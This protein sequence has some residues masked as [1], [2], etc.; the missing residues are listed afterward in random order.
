[1]SPILRILLPLVISTVAAHAQPGSGS[2][3]GEPEGASHGYDLLHVAIDV[4]FDLPKKLVIGSVEHSIH[5][6]G[7]TSGALEL[8]A[9]E[10]MGFRSVMVDGAPAR[11]RHTGETLAIY[12]P[13]SRKNDTMSVRIE[14]TVSPAKGL[15]FIQ[16]D[17]LMPL[18]RNQIWTQGEEEDNHFW[19]PIYDHPD[20]RT[21]TEIRATVPAGW[22]ALSNGRLISGGPGTDSGT[23]VWHYR[24]EKPHSTYLIMLAA[25]EFMVTHDTVDGIPLEYWTYP[26]MPE[27]VMPTFSRTPDAIRY[28]STLLGVPYPWNKYSQITIADFMFGGMENTTATT[29]ND[30]VLVDER[31]LLDYNPDGVIAHEA[32]HMWYGDLI[33]NRHW[34][35]LWLHESYA[36]Y[37]AAR[38]RGYRYGEDVFLEEMYDNGALGIQSQGVRGRNPLALG[39]NVTV[40]IYQRG[41]RVLHMLNRIVGEEAFWRAN[42]I[43]L[44]RHSY[45]LVETDDLKAAFNEATGSDLGWFFEQWIYKAGHPEYRVDKSWSKGTL[46]LRVR[47]AQ[48][49][50]PMTGLFRMPVPLEFHMRGG[51]VRDT[52]QVEKEDE[53]FTFQ[54]GEEPAYVIFDAGDAILKTVE[55]PRASDELV[56]QLMADRSID[57]MLA[58]EELAS[59][60]RTLKGPRGDQRRRSL[61][62]LKLLEREPAPFVREAIVN[63]ASMLDSLVMIDVIGRG[64]RD[65]SVTVRSAAVENSYLIASKSERARL[66]R[67]LLGDSSYA[68]VASVLGMLAVTDTSGLEPAL[69][70]MKG[71]RGRRDR[72]AL[73]WLGAV[74]SG[75]Y[76]SLADDVSDY[77]LPLY[78]TD[79]RVQAYYV[80]GKLDT[81]TPKVRDAIV[82]GLRESSAI[83]R[84]TAA[85]AA[86]SHLDAELRSML[87]RLRTELVGPQRSTVEGILEK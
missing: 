51:I 59:A 25:G 74:L 81:I 4:R 1:M 29:L 28:L 14:Y 58:V 9:A 78:N 34:G 33:T 87:E 36:T 23:S 45:G 2:R 48:N 72:L 61:A 44:E 6:L 82:R 66:L 63:K 85:G 65:T 52:I 21:T 18:K 79:T 37:L 15:Y 69:R 56:A 62:L 70:G 67:P 5:W 16:P 38:Y 7:G 19:V 84:S 30:Y 8:H 49:R 50:D 20:D 55:F 24:M 68:V 80:L 32:A 47:Q 17:S 31:G 22:K 13:S 11:Y 3:S 64:L 57:R 10:N 75:G 39:D 12:I 46:S 73:E 43:F 35:H 42:R 77:T 53:T 54:L 60:D 86:R 40:N 76:T 27:R 83:I 41:S 26:E 71:M